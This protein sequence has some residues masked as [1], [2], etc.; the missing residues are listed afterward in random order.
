MLDSAMLRTQYHVSSTSIHSYFS[1]SSSTSSSEYPSSSTSSMYPS[2]ASFPGSHTK[3]GLLSHHVLMR[4]KRWLNAILS[5]VFRTLMM[6]AQATK[7]TNMTTSKIMMMVRSWPAVPEDPSRTGAAAPRSATAMSS[8]ILKGRR[9]RTG[10][11]R[12]GTAPRQ[13]P[14]STRRTRR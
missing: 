5:S 14:Q 2:G 9:G 1:A 4:T 6:I 13:S 7:T 11:R 12:P 8:W 3:P 10:P